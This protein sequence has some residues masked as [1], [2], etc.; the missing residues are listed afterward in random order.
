[1]WWSKLSHL[2]HFRSDTGKADA[3]PS[4][5]H[6][7]LSAQAHQP[8]SVKSV[9]IWATL[10]P[11]DER[12]AMRC[13]GYVINGNSAA[14]PTPQVAIWPIVP[15]GLGGL[16]RRWACSNLRWARDLAM[17]TKR[18][19]RYDD[20]SSGVM[21]AIGTPATS[22]LYVYMSYTSIRLYDAKR[23]MEKNTKK[24]RQKN[25]HCPKWNETGTSQLF[26]RL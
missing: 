21:T 6:I 22:N 3:A 1:M 12:V 9:S 25:K 19:A 5:W 14:R 17:T 15:V 4:N 2:E 20:G 11:G 7:P 18:C 16:A 24:L 13:V 26:Q 23:I 10:R 8:T